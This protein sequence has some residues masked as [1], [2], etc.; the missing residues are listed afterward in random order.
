MKAINYIGKTYRENK[1][2]E[3][4]SII[5]SEIESNI[6]I[7]DA[8]MD[9]FTRLIASKNITASGNSMSIARFEGKLRL[10]QYTEV[11]TSKKLTKSEIFKA[12][13]KLA[14][15]FEGNYKA[16]FALALKQVYATQK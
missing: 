15:T 10:N 7:E 12:A 13:H 8:D 4:F 14:K 16:C 6:P 2:N 9:Y 3:I 1:T 11:I 5:S